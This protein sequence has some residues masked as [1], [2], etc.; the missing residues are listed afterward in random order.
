M[1]C[2]PRL[3]IDFDSSEVGKEVKDDNETADED[4]RC[5]NEG[6]DGGSIQND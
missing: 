5:K 2:R 4:R 6:L 1:N 3:S